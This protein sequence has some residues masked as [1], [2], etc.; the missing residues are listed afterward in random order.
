MRGY[1]SNHSHKTN[2]KPESNGTHGQC[3]IKHKSVLVL[4]RIDDV[5]QFSDRYIIK[6]NIAH[7]SRLTLANNLFC[8]KCKLNGSQ[9]IYPIVFLSLRAVVVCLLLLTSGLGGTLLL[10]GARLGLPVTVDRGLGPVPPRPGNMCQVQ[11]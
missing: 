9:F 4:I 5:K 10:A 11:S 6:L 7:G 3:R 2:F 8:V 1:Q